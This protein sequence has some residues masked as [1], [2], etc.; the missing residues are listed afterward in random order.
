MRLKLLLQMKK[1]PT[2]VQPPPEAATSS[3]TSSSATPPTVNATPF[4][5]EFILAPSV[6]QEEERLTGKRTMEEFQKEDTTEI[7]DTSASSSISTPTNS[8]ST[9]RPV[10]KVKVDDEDGIERDEDTSNSQSKGSSRFKRP[11]IL[12]KQDKTTEDEKQEENEEK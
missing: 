7:Q 9:E 6:P 3:A 12:G 2:I 11:N 10:K 1:P 8:E 4:T 5:P